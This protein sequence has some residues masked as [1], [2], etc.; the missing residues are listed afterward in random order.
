VLT[1]LC[2]LLG[3]K[4]IARHQ[5]A[6]ASIDIAATRGGALADSAAPSPRAEQG[7]VAAVITKFTGPKLLLIGEDSGSR[8]ARGSR[9]IGK[10]LG[11]RSVLLGTRCRR[12]LTIRGGN[13]R[14]TPVPH[15]R[16]VL[17]A[18][19]GIRAWGCTTTGGSL[20]M[21]RVDAGGCSQKPGCFRRVLGLC[22][23]P[24][25]RVARY[26]AIRPGRR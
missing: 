19:A 15:F 8:M 2:V 7:R 26:P 17:R 25:I 20:V 16:A 10:A 9:R 12:R 1:W 14:R 4:S 22:V 6:N 24:P 23:S 18:P 3:S 13:N 21:P 5:N 11:R